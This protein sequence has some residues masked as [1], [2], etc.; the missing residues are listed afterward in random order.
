MSVNVINLGADRYVINHGYIG[1]RAALFIEP[2]P[3]PGEVGA[4]ASKSGISKS[5]CV[6]GGT[7][8]TFENLA[9]AWAFESELT[10]TIKRIGTR[11]GM[12][13]T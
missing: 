4:D 13:L 1:E 3:E 10:E 6:D 8:I 9:C 5:K 12:G 11:R 7:A 2:A